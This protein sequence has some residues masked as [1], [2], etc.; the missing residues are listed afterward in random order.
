MVEGLM[1][2][3]SRKRWVAATRDA[4]VVVGDGEAGHAEGELLSCVHLAEVRC[5]L[6]ARFEGAHVVSCHSVGAREGVHISRDHGGRDLEECNGP[7]VPGGTV[8]GGTL[9]NSTLVSQNAPS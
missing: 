9:E 4:L 8:C 3:E 7:R 5:D 6:E 1:R 2:L